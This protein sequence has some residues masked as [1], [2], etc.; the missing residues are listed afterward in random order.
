[1]E[2]KLAEFVGKMIEVNC[3]DGL[4][5]SGTLLSLS[6]G[7]LSLETEDGKTLWIAASNVRAFAESSASSP[8]PGFIL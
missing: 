3:G 8:R 5:Y 7:V 1:M 6:E 4:A 2:R